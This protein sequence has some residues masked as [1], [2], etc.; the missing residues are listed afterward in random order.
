MKAIGFYQGLAVEDDNSFVD[1][2]KPIPQVA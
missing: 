1:F 2:E